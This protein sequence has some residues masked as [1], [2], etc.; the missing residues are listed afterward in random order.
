MQGAVIMVNVV[1]EGVVVRGRC[2]WDVIQFLH[3]SVGTYTTVW[4][5]VCMW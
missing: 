1:R 3:G 4:V 2:E 5:R